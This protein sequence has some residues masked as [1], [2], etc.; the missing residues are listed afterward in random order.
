MRV[1][2]S[3]A[4]HLG[5]ED[6]EARAGRYTD[7]PE[8]LDQLCQAGLVV[9]HEALAAAGLEPSALG[10][11]GLVL[12][13]ALGCLESDARYYREMLQK[14]LLRSNPRVF[15]YTLPNVV[16]GEVAIRLGS[17]GSNLV[18]DTG[19]AS[20][21][22]ALGEAASRIAGG[23]W[24]CALVM[25][26]DLIDPAAA[27]VLAALGS[28][29]APQ[30]WGF[31]LE[32][33]ARAAERGAPVVGLVEG[34]RAAFEAPSGAWPSPERF[35]GEGLSLEPG[36]MEARCSTSGHLAALSLAEPAPIWC[37]DAVYFPPEW[38]VFAGHFPGRPLVPGAELLRLAAER[39]G[40]VAE[41]ERARF[42]APVL[43]GER[44]R[45][46]LE[47]GA[48]EFLDEAG[49]ARATGHLRSAE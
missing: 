22:T 45:L 36:A 5:A 21:I 8:R 28:E 7:R 9:A 25:A 49:A 16:L 12:G 26:L 47:G 11:H 10:R 18:F 13:T 33:E 2:V 35:C 39:F 31:V 41:V 14:G 15:A 48:F 46:V 40:P 37:G 34:Y 29:G 1:V 27:E 4:L 43:P 42:R 24:D 17:R 32:S 6:L 44:L 23:E 30:L 3:A 38:P 19:R 20:G